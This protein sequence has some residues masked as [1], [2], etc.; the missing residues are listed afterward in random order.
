MN[1]EPDPQKHAS[2][3]KKKKNE[4]VDAKK[5]YPNGY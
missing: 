5:L 1:S 2:P 3:K 4:N